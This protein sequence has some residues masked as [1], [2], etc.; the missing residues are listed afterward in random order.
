MRCHIGRVLNLALLQVPISGLGAES[1]CADQ[2]GEHGGGHD[3]G[4]AR[5]VPPE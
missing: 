4:P 3:D 5:L 1:H 2:N